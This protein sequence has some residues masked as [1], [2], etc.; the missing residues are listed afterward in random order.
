MPAVRL[1]DQPE[2]RLAAGRFQW[3]GRVGEGER[4]GLPGQVLGPAAI[5]MGRRL[6]GNG[7][8]VTD[9]MRSGV[10]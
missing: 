1:C 8:G 6:Y 3:A 4:R 9:A 10:Q 5:R 7:R 2:V